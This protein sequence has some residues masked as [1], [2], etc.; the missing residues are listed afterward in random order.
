MGY[1]RDVSS[2]PPIVEV[3]LLECCVRQTSEGFCNFDLLD[4]E[5]FDDESMVLLYRCQKDEGAL[6]SHLQ[7]M[8]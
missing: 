2:G 3:T 8:L 1:G 4:A 5:F 6:I 7:C